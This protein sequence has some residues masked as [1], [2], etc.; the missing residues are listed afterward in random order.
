MNDPFFA[1]TG[2]QTIPAG[3]THLLVC[4]HG[5]G[6]D[7]NDLLSLASPL[8][9]A[10]A[11]QGISLGVA[12]PHAPQP[13]PFGQGR[14]WFRDLGWRFN[15][16]DGLALVLPAFNAYIQGLQAAHG[17]APAQTVL[18]GFSQGAMTLLGLLPQ[19]Q[20]QP[21]GVVALCGALTMP[22]SLSNPVKPPVL[23]V[24]GT[25]DDV[26]P[27]DASVQ[28]AQWLEQQGYPTTLRLLPN[29][30]HGIDAA[31]LAEL[32]VWLQELWAT[33]QPA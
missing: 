12:C 4:L 21:A 19:L 30:G 22:P 28:A 2:P 14:Q 13:T 8:Q 3:A 31:T 20:P 7:G 25:E 27:A 1:L 10:M 29:L 5:F 24:H 9:A 15:D 32:V 26:L 33:G 11:P 23:L 6:A 18:L 16:R 17:I